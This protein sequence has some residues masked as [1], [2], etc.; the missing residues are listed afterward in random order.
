MP[1]IL[2][3]YLIALARTS[4]IMLSKGGERQHSCL[5]PDPRWGSIWSFTIKYDVGCGI[6]L[7]VLYQVEEILL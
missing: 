5:V 7:D 6:F 1:I 3:S 2:F 4:S